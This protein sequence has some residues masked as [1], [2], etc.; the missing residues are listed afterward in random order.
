MQR[1]LTTLVLAGIALGAQAD[2]NI[3]SLDALGQAQFRLFS[4]DMGSAL[5]YKAMRSAEPFGI[6][7]FDIGLEVTSTKLANSGVFETATGGSSLST[8]P[9]PKLHAHKGLVA[10]LD[11]GLSY[12]A[13]PD[14]NIKLI[15]GE[16]SYAVLEGGLSMPT[17]GVRYAFSSL[18]GVDQLDFETRALEATVSKGL[19]L[20][21]PYAGAGKVWVTSTPKGTAATA[22]L[23]EESFS[24]NKLFAGLRASL[25]LVDFTLE[26]D[27][28][29]D[30]STYSLK[31]SIGF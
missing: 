19:T 21:T 7:G 26:A 13:V 6:S 1:L 4:E 16:L 8:L 28:T 23:K 11:V 2:N 27:K 18:T 29:G 24:Q 25:G 20:I 10:G 30:A 22:G 3:D 15:G 17:V 31:A 9:L 14:S 12:T 5:S